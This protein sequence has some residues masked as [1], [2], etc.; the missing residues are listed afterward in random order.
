VVL[1][2][3]S[4]AKKNSTALATHNIL[5]SPHG[6]QERLCSPPSYVPAGQEWESSGSH[7][8]PIT[9]CPNLCFSSSSISSPVSTVQHCC[10]IPPG[11]LNLLK[12]H[13]D[14]S[15]LLL[16]HYCPVFSYNT[17][18]LLFSPPA[19]LYPNEGDFGDYLEPIQTL[20]TWVLQIPKQIHSIPLKPGNNATCQDGG[21]SSSFAHT[22]HTWTHHIFP[23]HCTLG[24]GPA[25]DPNI[26]AVLH[27]QEA[28]VKVKASG[29]ARGEPRCEWTLNLQLDHRRLVLRK[30]TEGRKKAA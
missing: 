24:R 27:L 14:L 9:V 23:M 20:L 12:I 1:V 2:C 8:W 22:A 10:S 3:T 30:K 29:E 18:L 13:T 16:L 5:P 6:Y 11:L 15:S 28:V 7:L 26:N 21:T 25:W 17:F 4:A 19:Q